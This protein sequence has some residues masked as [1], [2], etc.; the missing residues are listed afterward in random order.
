MNFLVNFLKQ[1]KGGNQS[2]LLEKGALEFIYERFL[3]TDLHIEKQI[4]FDCARVLIQT[5]SIDLINC[6]E[7][8]MINGG[9]FTIHTLKEHFLGPLY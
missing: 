4:C 9:V 1:L 2:L 3:K 8:I 7:N 5:N 6:K